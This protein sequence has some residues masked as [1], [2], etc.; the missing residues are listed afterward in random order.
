MDG[1]RRIDGLLLSAYCCV[2]FGVALWSGRP[3]TLH[4]SVLPQSAREMLA[5]G[6]WVVPKKGGTP[7]LES[8]PL[9]QW[10]TVALATPFGRCDTE[11]I[12]RLG[13]ALVGWAVVLLTAWMGA[14]W[15]GR[16]TGLLAGLVMATTFQFTRY[17]WLAEDEIYLCGMITAVMAVF[18]KL[19]F[20]PRWQDQRE[21]SSWKSGL[22]QSVTG[23]NRW[24]IAFFVLLGM[25]N[26]IKGLFFGAALCLAPIG[27]YLLGTQE[28][29][30]IARYTWVW[31]AAIFLTIMLAWPLAVLQRYPDALEVWFFD[32]GGRVSGEYKL[33]NQPFWYYP[34]NLLWMIAPWTFVLPWS[35]VSTWRTA[36]EQ[37][38]SPERFLWVW[39]LGTIALLTIPGGKHHHYLLHALAPWALLSTRGLQH[40]WKTWPTWPAWAKQPA[41]GLATM[42]LPIMVCLVTF[43]D[44]LPGPAGIR[45]ALCLV[46]PLMV[47]TIGQS[48]V[49]RNPRQCVL[50]VSGWLLAGY[51]FGNWY[52]GAY[53]DKHRVDVAFLKTTRQIAA[54]KQLPLYVDLSRTPLSGFLD[55]FY[56]PDSTRAIHN[57]SFLLTLPESSPSQIL[58]LSRGMERDAL[59]RWGQIR[60]LAKS[61]H[62][63]TDY[64]GDATL[65]LYELQLHRSR[66]SIAAEE[67]RIS[68][69]QAMHR[70]PGPDLAPQRPSSIQQA[71]AREDK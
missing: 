67:I 70:H 19:E 37:R 59:G 13:P 25:T 66:P 56:Q 33:I 11:A 15:Y 69:M 57:A 60:P 45:W 20:D 29:R 21:V 44:K 48:M 32:L 17:A 52:S 63:T 39:G 40:L 24:V 58:V 4:E 71:S 9:P 2:L 30:H 1:L 43:G 61:A 35:I 55:L 68:P 14:L 38:T 27:L 23:R 49:G 62:S 6:D 16:Q 5:D 51:V 28:P 34:V 18:V 50:V 7:W 8:P 3:L 47:W 42:A 26:L 41:V 64:R 65:T 46:V 54:Q 31:G 36:W 12:V 22:I 53:F 10:I